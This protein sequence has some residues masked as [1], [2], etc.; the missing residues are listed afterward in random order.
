M[1]SIYGQRTQK[2]KK[3]NYNTIF[4]CEALNLRFFNV[5]VVEKRCK[6]I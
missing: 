4:F 5:N 2:K 6:L 3:I 1:S